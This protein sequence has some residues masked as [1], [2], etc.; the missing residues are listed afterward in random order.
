ML[1]KGDVLAFLGKASSPFGTFKE[2]KPAAAAPTG[3]PPKAEPVKVRINSSFTVNCT[4]VSYFYRHL[5]VLQ[6]DV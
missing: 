6:F 2:D 4:N 1:T 3:A 5:M